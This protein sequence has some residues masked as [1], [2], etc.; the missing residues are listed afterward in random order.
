M[1]YTCVQRCVWEHDGLQ[2]KSVYVVY[3]CATLCVRT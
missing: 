3:V 2:R 1:L